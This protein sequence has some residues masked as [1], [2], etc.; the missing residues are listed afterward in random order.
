MRGSVAMQAE[1]ET[2]W[3]STWMQGTPAGWTTSGD[4]EMN[5]NQFRDLTREFLQNIEGGLHE[6][7]AATSDLLNEQGV[8]GWGGSKD[9]ARAALNS[10]QQL[11][12]LLS[13]AEEKAAEMYELIQ[14]P[15]SG[16]AMAGV[17]GGPEAGEIVDHLERVFDAAGYSADGTTLK[18]FL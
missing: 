17:F 10:F 16:D 7:A 11:L 3:K 4:D 9:A 13:A 1:R 14:V 5:D 2:C 18:A 8:S 12:E 6:E 15:G